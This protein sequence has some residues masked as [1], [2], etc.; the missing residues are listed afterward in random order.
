MWVRD[1]TYPLR[2]IVFLSG[3]GKVFVF[4]EN[5]TLK[6]GKRPENLGACG[7]VRLCFLAAL[8]SD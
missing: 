3:A 8:S 1:F 7:E 6:V 5:Y 4:C 2:L